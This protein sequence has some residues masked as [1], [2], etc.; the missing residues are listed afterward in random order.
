MQILSTARCLRR[1]EKNC[2]LA[3]PFTFFPV[4]PPHSSCLSSE[5]TSDPLPRA[6]PFFF[7]SLSAPSSLTPLLLF[8]AETIRAIARKHTV[9]TAPRNWLIMRGWIAARGR[10]SFFRSRLPSAAF[11]SPAFFLSRPPSS[12]SWLVMPYRFISR[13]LSSLPALSTSCLQMRPGP[14][15]YLSS[16]IRSHRALRASSSR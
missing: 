8:P 13:S 15:N 9:I 10:E 2:I 7:R 16:S 11:I 3:A 5:R 12:W 1:I 6:V 14:F 4:P